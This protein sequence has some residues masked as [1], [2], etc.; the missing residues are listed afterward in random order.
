M[1]SLLKRIFPWF[2][3]HYPAS[4][5]ALFAG[6]MG[7]VFA[8]ELEEAHQKSWVEV[9]I[10]CGHEL[11]DMPMV[12]WKEF[13]M[14]GKWKGIEKDI[15]IAL[16]DFFYHPDSQLSSASTP[17]K[18][19]SWKATIAGVFPVLSF[20]L[21]TAWSE[22]INSNISWLGPL[23]SLWGFIFAYL[24]ML[25]IFGIG[26]MKG[27]PRWAYPS[28]VFVMIFSLYFMGVATPGLQIFGH[29][30]SSTEL[31]G[32]RAWIPFATMMVIVLLLSRSFKSGSRFFANG[33]KDWTLVPFALYGIMPLLFWM[34]FDEVRSPYAAPYLLFTAI[35]LSLGALGYMRFSNQGGRAWALFV[36]LVPPAAVN[37]IALSIYW[38]GR[39]ETWMSYPG[40]GEAIAIGSGA[41]WLILL[42]IM[43][44]PGIIHWLRQRIGPQKMAVS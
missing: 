25:I 36:G 24:L 43:F 22:V 11:G 3:L 39:Q 32:L 5:R 42:T 26:W 41:G 12:F 15:L 35:S 9:L 29:T 33:L 28:T 16:D 44:L 18:P 27:F 17:E 30:F 23:A 2:F 7:E 14:Q 21:V 19:A 20:G 34:S 40:D 6:E 31:W 37:S 10:V 13:Q 1:L 8:R 4:F 38:A